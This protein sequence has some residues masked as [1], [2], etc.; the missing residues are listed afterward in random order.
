M[1]AWWDFASVVLN[2]SREC[3]EG[4]YFDE[5]VLGTNTC[6]PECGEFLRTPLVRQF[7]ERFSIVVGI[8]GSVLVFLI[9]ATVQR[10]KLWV[11]WNYIASLLI[12][13]SYEE[14]TIQE[15]VASYRVKKSCFVF[16][17]PIHRLSFPSVILVYICISSI[18]L[19]K[20]SREWLE[21][22]WACNLCIGRWG[23]ERGTLLLWQFCSNFWVIGKKLKT[24][25]NEPRNWH[26]WLWSYSCS[27]FWFS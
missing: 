11:C 12:S 16:S 9:A 20:F 24:C 2:Q 19:S 23:G 22:V 26:V 13:Q 4:F 17:F 7:F 10:E 25:S 18:I 3:S 21:K 14:C 5:D 27:H 6:R 15:H 8:I 1:N